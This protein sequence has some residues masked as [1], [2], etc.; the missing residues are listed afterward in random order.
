[1][2]ARI[3]AAIVAALGL[4]VAS[5]AH[6]QQTAATPVSDAQLREACLGWFADKTYVGKLVNASPSNKHGREITFSTT[7]QGML[8]QTDAGARCVVTVRAQNDARDRP[9]IREFLFDGASAKWV[10]ATDN[11]NWRT[12]TPEGTC[13]R[14]EGEIILGEAA[15]GTPTKGLLVYDANETKELF[16]PK[17]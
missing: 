13:L 3:L 6:A 1:M 2:F 8:R 10:W 7:T 4:A 15:Y 11:R 9:I 12:F 16:C 14:Y 5:A 17:P